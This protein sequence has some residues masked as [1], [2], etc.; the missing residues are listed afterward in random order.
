MR[1]QKLDR[2]IKLRDNR[3]E[4]GALRC[5]IANWQSGVG[6][7][8]YEIA[9]FS[10]GR[11][12]RE[13]A[14]A[15]ESVGVLA[16][17]QGTIGPVADKFCVEPAIPDH[18]PGDA[19]RQRT[20][21]ARSHPQPLIRTHGKARAPG[22]DHDEA[23]AAGSRRSNGCGVIEPGGTRVVPPQH[24]AFRFFEIGRRDRTPERK[25]MGVV[26][27]P[28][29]DL[30]AIRHVRAAEGI[31]ETL[32]PAQIIRDRGAARRRQ[33]EGD[34]LRTRLFA[35]AIEF[36][37]GPVERLLPCDPL[38]ARVGIALRPCPPERIKLPL[39]AV[40]DLGGRAAFY[41]ERLTGR[42]VRIWFLAD[43][44]AFARHQDSA[45]ARL[46]ECAKSRR[47]GFRLAI[48]FQDCTS[49]VAS[50]AAGQMI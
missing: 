49:I 19:K 50:C 35:N 27:V 44:A 18:L 3:L 23:R 47:P 43:E 8:C 10:T 45:A 6:I 4:I 7:P 15:Q 32:D 5:R 42:M 24:D 26:L 38:P 37:R 30:G 20:V 39:R 41:A 1:R 13:I 34:R 36:G 12:R 31:D 22:I 46:A 2:R 28:I 21:G 17:Q 29:A 48:C 40:H 25:G 11:R 16:N 14:S 9:V 33:T